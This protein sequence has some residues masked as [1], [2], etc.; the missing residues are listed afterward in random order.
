[1][2]DLMEICKTANYGAQAIIKDLAAKSGFNMDH[3]INPSITDEDEKTVL[4][5]LKVLQGGFYTYEDEEKFVKQI[6][7]ILKKYI[8]IYE[9]IEQDA[10]AKR[11]KIETLMQSLPEILLK[12][13]KSITKIKSEI[14]KTVND[15]IEEGQNMH[16]INTSIAL[17]DT[18]HLKGL[19][20]Q[21]VEGMINLLLNK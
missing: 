4:K 18:K 10:E 21:Y 12:H 6:E 5:L 8:A 19:G 16:S 13:D 20:K 15:L 11:K 7:V 3:R 9:Q 2:K 14:E 1:M 17:S